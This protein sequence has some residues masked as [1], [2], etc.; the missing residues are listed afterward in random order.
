MGGRR[1]FKRKNACYYYV[2]CPSVAAGDIVFSH[3]NGM[4]S[5]VVD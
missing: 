5:V 3:S 1:V 4:R 2:D